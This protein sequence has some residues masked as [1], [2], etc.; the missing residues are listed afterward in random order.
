MKAEKI[1]LIDLGWLAGDLG[2]F[3]PGPAGGA[4][5]KSNRNPQRV[6][7]EVPIAAT[8]VMHKDGVIL[9]DTGISPKAPETHD[10]GLVEAFPITKLTEENH[11][12]KQLA[13]IGLKPG[14]ISFVV[15][16]HLHLDHIGQASVFK[17]HKVP[18]IVQK[19]ELEYALYMIWQGKGGAYDPA[20]LLPLMGASWHPIDDKV[21]D[22]VD[23]V[24]LEF[25]GGHTPGHQLMIVETE[26]GNNYIF[27]G[28]YFHVPQEYEIEAKGWLLGDAD[29]WH[30]YLRK[31]KVMMKAKRAKLVIAHDPKV[32]EKYPSAP[33]AM[34]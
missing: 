21:F 15:I 17:D 2:W 9:F 16:S 27:T 3:L 5:T 32:W 28:D 12:E 22:L 34:E 7:Q 19:K 29:E 30:S 25:T 6:W 4:M 31:L 33:K 1:Y 8:V 24:R 14:D 11:I 26:K 23:G 10:K 20:D 13:K 18:I